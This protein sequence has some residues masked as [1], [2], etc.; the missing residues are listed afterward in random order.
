M[1]ATAAQRL[2][3]AP[4]CA[5]LD[6]TSCHGDGRYNRAE[7]PDAE[8]MHMTRGYS[9][10]HRPALNHG[11]LDLMVEH[12][13]GMPRLM[14]P[15]SGHSRDTQTFGE[16]VTAHLQPL[17]TP[18]GTTYLVADRALSRED[19][20]PKLATTGSQWSTRV[21]ATLTAGQDALAHAIPETMAPLAESSRD[22]MLAATSGG[23]AQRWMLV[24]AAHRRPQAQRS[25]DTPWCTPSTAATQAGQN[26]CRTAF[27]CTADA[28]H[29]LTT[30]RG[31]L[32]APSLHASTIEPRPRDHKRGRPRPG[33]PPAQ[34]VYHL[35]GALT[36]ALAAHAALVAPERG[37]V[38]ATN[39]LDAC[40]LPPQDLLAGYQGQQAVE[41]GFRF[42]KDP[43]CL[44]SSLSLTK[45][46][47]IMA[48][49]MGRTVCLLVYA[50]LADRI[51]KTLK[52]QD[53]TVPN[54]QGQPVQNPTARWVFPYFVGIHL[55]RM[56]GEGA[57]VLNL[58]DQHQQLLRLLGR[59]YEAFYS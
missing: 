19:N 16:S 57:F 15:L 53:A 37:F 40:R 58:N 29:A 27:A 31:G 23:V 24:Y 59:S 52:D 48:L 4:M 21:P 56:R 3:L 20:L 45:L 22:H 8:V 18:Y 42:W 49:L 50:A 44:A 43:S 34:V 39:E 54:Q 51:R 36:S 46:E 1:A 13:A 55:L 10:D 33:A 6:R 26:R 14:Q 25:V 32:Q 5:H 38:L 47:R 30:F 9:R 17:H 7:A 11:M 2:G 35:T 28:Q 41:R 12:P